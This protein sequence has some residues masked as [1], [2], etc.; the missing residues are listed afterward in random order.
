MCHGLPYGVRGIGEVDLDIGSI[1][2]FCK[3]FCHGGFADS[4]GSANEEGGLAILFP[5]PL[6]EFLVNLSLEYSFRIFHPLE[7]FK[8]SDANIGLFVGFSKSFLLFLYEISKSF[9]MNCTASRGR[10]RGYA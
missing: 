4:S 5:L 9:L 8:V 10:G 1:L 2:V 6:S 3:L 7:M